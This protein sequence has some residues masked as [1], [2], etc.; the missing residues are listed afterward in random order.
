MN[1][2]V[3]GLIEMRRPSFFLFRVN[4][5][6]TIHTDLVP[7]FCCEFN[8]LAHLRHIRWK[9]LS[10]VILFH[11]DS[12]KPVGKTRFDEIECLLRQGRRRFRIP[13]A[14]NQAMPRI[15]S[16]P[17]SL[18]PAVSSIEYISHKLR[19]DNSTTEPIISPP[20]TASRGTVQVRSPNSDATNVGLKRE[21]E[22]PQEEGIS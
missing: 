11:P 6:H 22:I 17:H 14:A 21:A 20:T 16:I 4:E 13:M 7:V 19:V 18:C 10:G 12:F 5:S 8:S 2:Q 1:V 15:D 3:S 9:I